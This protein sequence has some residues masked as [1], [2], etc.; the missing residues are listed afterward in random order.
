MADSIVAVDTVT[1]IGGPAK[2]NVALDFGP[3][4]QRGS[5]IL[6]GLGK[7]NSLPEEDFSYKP[8]LLD[9]YINLLTTDSEYLY[10]YQYVSK[11]GIDQWTRIFKIIPNVYNTNETVTFANGLATVNIAIANTTLALLPGANISE[12]KLNTHIDIE[13]A[14]ETNVEHIYPVIS[15]FKIG[16]PV[17]NNN[18]YYLP[19]YLSAIELVPT[20]VPAAPYLPTPVTGSRT[21]HISINVI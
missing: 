4:G 16:S 12:L 6:Y 3:Q 7:P 13:N 10:L 21:A 2:V 20:G 11:D 18:Q 15:S 19:I 8:Q 9:W 1:L 17:V 5:L 14:A